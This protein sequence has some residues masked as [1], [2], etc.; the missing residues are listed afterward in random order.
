MLLGGLRTGRDAVDLVH[1]TR[2]TILVAIDYPIEGERNPK[3][4]AVLPA[5]P[6]IQRAIRNTPLALQLT[7]DWLLR[8]PEVDPARVD[9]VGVSLG[10]TFACVAGALDERF[11]RVWSIH[12]AGMPQ[13]L[14]DEGLR[15]D[16]AFAPA[17]RAVARLATKLAQAEQLA[18]EHWVG[19]IAPREVV[20]VNALDDERLPRECVEALH[21]A[22][23]EPK[24][25]IWLPGQHIEPDRETIV[26]NLIEMVLERIERTD[27]S[28]PRKARYAGRNPSGTPIWIA[29]A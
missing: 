25:I 6:R 13:R 22:A 16:I 17:R 8:Q 24:T 18:P 7:L 1:D 3:G 4:L 5:V 29:T 21:S 27:R 10:S 11:H 23:R 2:G 28:L 14:I 19:R 12:G 26:R 9:L 20:L 15:S